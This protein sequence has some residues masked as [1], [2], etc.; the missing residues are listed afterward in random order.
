MAPPAAIPAAPSPAP[1]RS[2]REA[3]PVPGEGASPE[4]E[5][6]P[7]DTASPLLN[8]PAMRQTMAAWKASPNERRAFRAPEIAR[9]ANRFVA[10]HPAAPLTREIEDTLPA[11]LKQRAT[12]C[13]DHAQPVLAHLYFRAYRHLRFA[14]ADPELERRFQSLRPADATPGPRRRP[15]APAPDGR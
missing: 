12:E 11:Y 3:A 6:T 8:P 15:T 2:E 7:D 13:L 5:P 14:P 9:T 1:T 10:G 4:T